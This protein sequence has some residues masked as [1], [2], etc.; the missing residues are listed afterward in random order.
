ML[1]TR[2]SLFDDQER[3]NVAAA[4]TR[5]TL[6]WPLNVMTSAR[7][8]LNCFIRV[9]LF[10][11][12]RYIQWPAFIPVVGL[13][14]RIGS[15]LVGCFVSVEISLLGSFPVKS[16]F[17]LFCSDIQFASCVVRDAFVKYFCRQPD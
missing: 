6:G 8:H 4:I 7:G 14:L 12:R 11:L 1:F 15:F 16:C 2:C 9:E 17:D 13:F 5:K 10:R 3:L